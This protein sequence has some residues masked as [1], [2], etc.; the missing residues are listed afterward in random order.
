MAYVAIVL[1]LATALVFTSPVAAVEDSG[2]EGPQSS[3]VVAEADWQRLTPRQYLHLRY[4]EVAHRLDRVANCES[5]WKPNAK[6]RL[7]SASGL[8]QF[9]S[10]TWKSTRA[11]MGRDTDL[12][13]RFDAHENIDTAVFLWNG[14]RGAGHWECV[15][16]HSA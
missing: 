13:L 1:G 6:S 11:A 12:D 9:I 8:F 10:G 7:S 4:P 15:T 14:G 5:G 16:K 2:D 3:L